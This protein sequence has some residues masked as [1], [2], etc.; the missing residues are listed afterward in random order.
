MT[1]IFMALTAI[2]AQTQNATVDVNGGEIIVMG[3]TMNVPD[4]ANWH[5]F[6]FEE[7]EVIGQ[8]EFVISNP[9]PGANIGTEVPDSSWAARDDWDITFHATDIRTNG[10]EALLIA[11][12]SSTTP[13]A[14][15]YANLEY[16]PESGYE[17]DEM[18]AGTFIAS[19]TSMPP[20]RATQ[21]SAC[22]ATHGWAVF[23]SNNSMISSK[24]VVFKLSN[25][26]YVKVY[27]K[28]F[29][30]EEGLPG[31]IEMEYEFISLEDDDETG[32]ERIE[33]GKFSIYPNPAS[34]MLNVELKE[35]VKNSS[36]MIY[37]MA[38]ALVKQIPANVGLNQIAISDL[39]VG[40]YFVRVDH[41]T[42]KFIVK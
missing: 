22:K 23:E 24:V 12:T 3:R 14:E 29:F 37:N 27:L 1:L 4:Y 15:V 10:L 9:S 20:L 42:H 21:M 36:I 30:D 8:S 41:L 40:T 34:E 16:A 31:Y 32:I 18:I 19:M 7:G 25:E 33:D 38:G 35:A 26:K 11:D 28:E 13:L 5:Y 17:A 6:S 2:N 39:S